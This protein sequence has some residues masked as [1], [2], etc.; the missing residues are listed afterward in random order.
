MSASMAVTTRPPRPA[1]MVAREPGALLYAPEVCKYGVENEEKKGD[2]YPVSLSAARI[3][4]DSGRALV[5]P[6][7]PSR[8]YYRYLHIPGRAY[9][10]ALVILPPPFSTLPFPPFPPFP[11]HH[12]WRF[13]RSRWRDPRTPTHIWSRGLGHWGRERESV[14]VFSDPR[15]WLALLA[16][17]THACGMCQPM[18]L[19]R[20]PPHH[21]VICKSSMYF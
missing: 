6:C 21:P 17:L 8:A 16:P 2:T 1:T 9:S 18:L 11:T 10:P 5:G 3:R 4:P 12:L 14:L 7:D 19:F 15:P 13:S 20:G